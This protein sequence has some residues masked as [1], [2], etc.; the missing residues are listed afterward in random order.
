VSNQKKRYKMLIIG[1]AWI[2]FHCEVNNIEGHPANGEYE[3]HGD[4]H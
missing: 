4:Q 3:H 1:K 2:E